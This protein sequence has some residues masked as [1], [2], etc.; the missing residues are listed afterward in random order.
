M[1]FSMLPQLYSVVTQV[2]FSITDRDW[3]VKFKVCLLDRSVLDVRFSGE[4]GREVGMC[5]G[6]VMK[7]FN[8]R[9]R[10]AALT[11]RLSRSYHHAR[12]RRVMV[13]IIHRPANFP[14]LH[15]FANVDP[16]RVRRQ[17]RQPARKG[18]RSWRERTRLRKEGSSA[19]SL[20][21]HINQSAVSRQLMGW[22]IVECG[23]IG[24]RADKLGGDG[25]T[26]EC[27]GL[28]CESALRSECSV[29]RRDVHDLWCHHNNANRH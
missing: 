22:L 29:L 18:T 14:L 7:M 21:S 24:H 23:D 8:C 12:E 25:D 1:L 5:S 28:P 11:P 27:A 10:W 4:N 26:C 15:R 6:R 16:W 20:V 13:R 19:T 17:R 9:K 2:N 3:F